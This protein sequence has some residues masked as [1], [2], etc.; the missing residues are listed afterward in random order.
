MSRERDWELF[1]PAMKYKSGLAVAYSNRASPSDFR[2]DSGRFADL[3][4]TLGRDLAGL[5]GS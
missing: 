5:A 3:S 1:D 4:G 2:L